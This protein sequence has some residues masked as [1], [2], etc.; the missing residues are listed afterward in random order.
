[1]RFVEITKENFTEA[2]ALRPKRSQYRFTRRETVLYSLG[3]AY[4]ASHAQEHMPFAIETEGRL[5]GAVRLRNYGHGIG[6]AAFFIDRE[7]QRKGLG[8]KAMLYL[9]DWVKEHFPSAK[10]IELAV[11]PDNTVA[12]RL[13]EILGYRYTGVKNADGEVDMELQLNCQQ[14]AATDG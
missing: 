3:R 10:E 1:M 14:S 9:I 7:H 2:I 11:H 4:T 8:K 5:V 13:Y 12:C 6:C